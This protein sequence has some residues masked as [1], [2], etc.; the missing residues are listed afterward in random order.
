MAASP[1]LWLFLCL[2]R[3][4]SKR[5]VE[6]HSPFYD[7]LNEDLNEDLKMLEEEEKKKRRRSDEG[8]SCFRALSVVGQCSASYACAS[9]VVKTKQVLGRSRCYSEARGSSVSPLA[10]SQRVYELGVNGQ[11][12]TWN[13]R[14]EDWL[15]SG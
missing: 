11:K 10:L 2:P 12:P 7:D 15:V 6:T 8:A 9:L 4:R 13:R 3:A 5:D 14:E 1:R